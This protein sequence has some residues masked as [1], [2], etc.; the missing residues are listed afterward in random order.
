MGRER[1]DAGRW[2]REERKSGEEIVLARANP[3]YASGN[4][5]LGGSYLLNQAAVDSSNWE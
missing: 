1:R 2:R 3:P 4:T 5:S